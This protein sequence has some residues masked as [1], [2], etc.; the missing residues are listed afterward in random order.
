VTDVDSPW[1][2]ALDRFLLDFSDDLVRLE[3][4]ANNFGLIVLAHLQTLAT[5]RDFESRRAWKTRIVRALFDRGLSADEIRQLFRIID[6]L[7]DLPE[8]LATQ[9]KVEMRRFE[10]ERKMPYITSIERLAKEEGREEGREEVRVEYAEIAIQGIALAL[11]AKFG[12]AGLALLPLL[13]GT[14]D[15]AKLRAVQQAIR[16]GLALEE[17]QSIMERSSE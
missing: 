6:W 16:S 14:Q 10:E 8:E 1:K 13:E 7:M 15:L 3:T 17:V 12:A 5:R 9:F 4:A 2:E 11:E